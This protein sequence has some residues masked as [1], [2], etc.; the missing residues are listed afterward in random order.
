MLSEKHFTNALI[1][2]RSPYLQQHAHNPV[3]WYP[4][5]NEALE[6]AKKEDKL[7]I[8]SIGYSTCHWC[9]V[10]ERES[11][12]DEE[13]AA[14]MNKYF[15]C[16]KVDR[17]ERPDIDQVY[18]DAVQLMTGHGGWPLNC[19]T[20][21]DQR[22]IFGGT[23]FPRAKW[24]QVLLQLANF[25]STEK[26]KALEYAQELTQGIN[27]LESIIKKQTDD[28]LPNI[29]VK[30]IY[31]SWSKQ[32]DTIYGGPNRAPKFSL[33]NTYEF[34]L[35]LL[36]HSHQ[37]NILSGEQN[38]SLKK[39][40]QLTLQ[41]MAY[42]GIYDQLG[43][44]FARYSTD[45]QWKVPHFEKMLYD[46]AQ[47]ISLYSNAYKYLPDELYKNVVE[48]TLEF[49]TRELTSPEGGF[50]SALDA[51]SEGEEGKFYVWTKAE[52]EM[53]LGESATLFKDYYNVND[54]GFWEKENY[55]LLRSE[56]D[57]VIVERNKINVDQLHK[58]IA[59][60][61]QQLMKVRDQRIHPGLD[62][63]QICAWNA[64]MLKGYV[65]AYNAFNKP[66]YLKT[67]QRNADFILKH[68]SADDGGLL[69][70]AGHNGGGFLDD[71]AFC[72]EAFISLYQCTFNE[73]YLQQAHQW[74]KYAMQNFY[75][76]AS[77]LFFY[78][79]SNAE[80]L[81]ARKFELQDNVIP[82]SNS[83]MAKNL[84]L[85]SRYYA[86]PEYE[87]ISRQMLLHLIKEVEQ[88]TPW[89][90]N[91]AKLYLQMNFTFNEVCIC[92]PKA[93]EYR[94]EIS[95]SYLPNIL[96]AGSEK[97]SKLPLIQNR[98]KENETLIY[99]CTKNACLNPVKTVDKALTLILPSLRGTKQ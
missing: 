66:E 47:L 58:I 96:L 65:D 53:H 63:K 4:W 49:I 95:K 23:Y 76:E 36:Y 32:F 28:D 41:C 19:I 80:T 86:L 67:A 16:I 43:G 48:E 21:P 13:T 10:M 57:E 77:G 92:G 20:L 5:G 33:P 88:Q 90:S 6:K 87:T 94:K 26:T 56:T 91:W 37:K 8:I 35:Q 83:A 46:N 22:P 84:L 62:N 25:Y 79:A 60:C 64:L 74:M 98:N 27:R 29:D 18:M 34:L 78:T 42:G 72:I 14:I 89:Y 7:M 2:E 38:Q 15:V 17:E 59:E 11:F 71:Y 30:L 75:D 12:E 68:L 45:M 61:K 93:N 50:Y 24:Q 3:Q 9:H 82:A 44:G 51:D 97:A 40:L 85:L 73:K 70:H 54:K 31:E 52:V 99:V 81:I 55:I 1:H 39:H 69:R